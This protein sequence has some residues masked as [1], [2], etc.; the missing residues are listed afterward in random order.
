[1]NIVVLNGSPR[2][3]GNTK[4]LLDA[5]VK[6]AKEKKHSVEV[7]DL[8]KMHINGCLACEHCHSTE[9]GKCCQK[10]DMQ[11]I[12]PSL[13][14]SDIIVFASPIYYFNVTAPLQACITRFYSIGKPKAKEYALI[15]SSAS[16]NVYSASVEQFKAMMAYFGTEIIAIK[17][18]SGSN[19]LSDKNLS[20]MTDFGYSL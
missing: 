16:E 13:S 18:F 4:G 10:D 9:K 15:L 19:Q 3:N 6:G 14:K 7:F 1:M 2:V 17:T 20:E 8:Y 12:Y 5:F 11:K